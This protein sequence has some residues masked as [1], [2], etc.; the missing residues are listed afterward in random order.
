MWRSNPVKFVTEVF[1]VTPEKWQKNVLQSIIDNERVSVRSGHGVGKTAMLSWLILQ[2]LIT[3]YPSK[4]ACT[5]PTAHQLEDVL[6]GEVAKWYR[7]M[8]DGLKNLLRLSRDRVEVLT[9]PQE[10]F[11]VARTARKEQPEA[12]QGFHSENMLFIID[13]ASGVEDIIFEVGEGSMSTPGAKTLMTGNPTRTSGYFYDS[14]HSSRK[15]WNTH[16]V[17]CSD[18]KMV[19]KRYVD[20]MKEKYGSTSNIYRVRVLGEFPSGDE[21]AVIPLALIEDAVTRQV[22]QVDGNMVWGLDVARFGSDRSSL[23]KRM[24]NTLTEPIRFWRGKD[25]MQLCGIVVDEFNKMKGNE[26]PHEILIDSIG[27]GAG[28]VD[29]LM[30][31]GLPARG[32]N[33]AETPSI[34]TRFNRLRDE[35]WWKTREWFEERNTHIPDQDELIAELAMPRYNYT[36]A[37]KLKVESKAEM[38]KAGMQSPDLADALCLT[39]AFQSVKNYNRIIEYP[40]LGIV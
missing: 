2:W 9:A 22:D 18:S 8:P 14:F 1:Q 4:V 17:A 16:K 34:Q 32:I 36:S 24:E 25:L 31:L 13:E 7:R 5:A 3:R 15:L 39:F 23:A 11:A 19:T 35:L 6:W 27:V 33:V 21:D 10:S 20:E 26:I 38:R 12:F 30:E 37:G 40:E 29:R 28:V